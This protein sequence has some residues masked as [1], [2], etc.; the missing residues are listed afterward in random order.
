MKKYLILLP[1]LVTTIIS[2]VEANDSL[3]E[4]ANRLFGVIQAPE[5]AL[6]KSEKVKLGQQLFWDK[7][8]SANGKVAFASCH[9]AE[10]WSSD[11]RKHSP[12]ASNMMTSRHSQPI[13]NAVGQIGLRW[14]V[15]RIDAQIQA[16]GS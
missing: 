6:L 15:D 8:I 9:K 1:L 14:V 2:N 10:D 3:R 16:Q 11:K 13:F 7:R 12:D 4:T 5:E